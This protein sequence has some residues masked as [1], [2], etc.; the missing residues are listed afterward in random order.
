MIY[1]NQTN[2][3][4]IFHF[5]P[6]C[7]EPVFE[8]VTA[9]TLKY[10]LCS[11]GAENIWCDTVTYDDM[12]INKRQKTNQ[13]F[14]KMLDK[15]R[16]GFPDDQTLAT[17]SERVFSMPILKKL[18]ILQEAPV[19][20]FPKVDMCREFNEEMLA[21]LP[22]PTKELEATTLIDETVTIRDSLEEKVKKKLEELKK[23]VT[24]ARGLEANLKLVVEARV[25]LHAM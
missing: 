10:T 9:K 13:K 7:G 14:S 12:T 23:D 15:E 3:L 2:G 21:D 24:N 8:Q 25:M 4:D 19:C 11:M 6:V 1:W 16:R 20:L 22:S 17:L 18:K 5:P